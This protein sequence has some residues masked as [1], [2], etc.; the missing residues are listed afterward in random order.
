MEQ[1]EISGNH[2]S[3]CVHESE[4]ALTAKALAP[5]IGVAVS[6]VHKMSRGRVIPFVSIGASQRGRRFYVSAVKAVLEVHAG[7]DG[8]GKYSGLNS[9]S[10][11]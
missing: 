11:K 9:I 4:H 2:S 8:D 3:S 6:T 5:L 7:G 10:G 1:Q